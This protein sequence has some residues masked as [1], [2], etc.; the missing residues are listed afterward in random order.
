MQWEGTWERRNGGVEIGLMLAG[1]NGN[2]L[3]GM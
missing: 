3:R 2:V 1:R